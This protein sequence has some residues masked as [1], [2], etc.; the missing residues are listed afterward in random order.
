MARRSDLILVSLQ[1]VIKY[2]EP[3]LLGHMIE[4]FSCSRDP[5]VERF[6]KKNAIF[7]EHQGLS[8]TY[9]YV[10]L[11]EDR[12][13]IAGYFSVAITVTSFVQITRS[14]KSKVLGFKPGRDAKDHFGGILIAQLA[15]GDGFSTVELD[16]KGM[17]QNAEEVIE[18]GRYYL[19]GKIVYLDCK[20]LLLSFYQSHGYRPIVDEPFPDGFYKLYKTLPLQ[21]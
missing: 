12:P 18:K 10:S 20:E 19:G 5:D 15:R 6:L 8:R 17:I 9:L 7:F 2:T 21:M 16:G 1:E 14:R 13:R 3:E 4:E 11:E